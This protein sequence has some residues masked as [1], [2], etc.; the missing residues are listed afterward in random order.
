[1]LEVTEFPVKAAWGT[2]EKADCRGK[3]TRVLAL[4]FIGWD[5]LVK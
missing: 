1:M 3:P 2:S 4:A 5:I